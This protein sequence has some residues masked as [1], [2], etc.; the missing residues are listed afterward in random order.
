MQKQSG[1]FTSSQGLGDSR[2]DSKMRIKVAIRHKSGKVSQGYSSMN[3]VFDPTAI[4][5]YHKSAGRS[6][7]R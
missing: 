1:L 4:I 7:S 2:S 6:L 5:A 3:S